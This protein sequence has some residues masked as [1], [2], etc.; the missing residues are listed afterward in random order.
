[1]PPDGA[2]TGFCGGACAA[3]A[4]LGD[5]VA[6]A[7]LRGREWND[8]ALAASDAGSTGRG[9]TTVG[10]GTAGAAVAGGAA[11]GAT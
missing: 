4:A 10:A 3:L 8:E 5:G 7:T 1:V 2:S 6:G 11:T 9:A